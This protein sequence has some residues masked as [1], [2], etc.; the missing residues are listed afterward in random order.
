MI[1]YWGS[2]RAN[3]H[4]VVGFQLSSRKRWRLDFDPSPDKL[5]HVNE[6]N[7]DSTPGHQKIVHKVEGQTN[8][9]Q[10]LL[11]YHKWTSKY[12]KRRTE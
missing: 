4:L 12:G 7:F 1:P 9:T 10:V 11:Y 3:N 5:V 8:D 2:M 6:E